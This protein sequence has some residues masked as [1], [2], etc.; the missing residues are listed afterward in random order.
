MAMNKPTSRVRTVG[1]VASAITLAIAC[2]SIAELPAG[3]REATHGELLLFSRGAANESQLGRVEIG[4]GY[5]EGQW[6]IASWRS[7]DRKHAGQAVFFH[8]CDHWNLE[9]AKKGE[10]TKSDLSRVQRLTPQIA[11]RLEAD[12]I[13]LQRA[14]IP[15]L[16][17]SRPARTC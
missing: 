8:I 2:L 17:P 14:H 5:V 10:F 15:Y 7:E 11:A 13:L 12:S 1:K 6:A 9:D 4:G 16:P 3:A